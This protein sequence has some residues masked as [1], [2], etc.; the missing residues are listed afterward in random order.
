MK[1]FLGPCCLSGNIYFPT[2]G[3]QWSRHPLY[4]HP[5][6]GQTMS[7]N[8]FTDILRML[9]FVDRSIINP[10]DRLFKIRPILEKNS[11]KYKIHL[12]SRSINI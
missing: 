12:F 5:I 3:K 9:R 2:L 11:C 1:K 4:Y 6:F 10:E 8:R 7:R